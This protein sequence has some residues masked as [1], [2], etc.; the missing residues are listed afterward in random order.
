MILGDFHIDEKECVESLNL[1]LQAIAL[2]R[3]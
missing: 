1:D 3:R 2:I